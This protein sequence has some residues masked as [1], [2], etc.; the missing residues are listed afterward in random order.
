MRVVRPVKA[1]LIATSA[2]DGF[3]RQVSMPLLFCNM[4]GLLSANSLITSIV[5]WAADRTLACLMQGHKGGS[6]AYFREGK[7]SSP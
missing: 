3:F 2:L 4:A 6:K 5:E 7:A 1:W